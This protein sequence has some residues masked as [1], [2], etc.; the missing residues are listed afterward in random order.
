MDK[1]TTLERQDSSMNKTLLTAL[2]VLSGCS[3]PPLSRRQPQKCLLPGCNKMTTHNGGY[4]CAQ[5]CKLHQEMR[6]PI[7]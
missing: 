4:C 2:L 3:L 1:L 5:H 6:H 7:Y